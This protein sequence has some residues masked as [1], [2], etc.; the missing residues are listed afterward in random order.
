MIDT[1]ELNRLDAQQ[2]REVVQSLIGKVSAQQ[3]EISRRDAVVQGL[4]TQRI[5]ACAHR[6]SHRTGPVQPGGRESGGA[7]QMV[8]VV[9]KNP[10]KYGF[11][12]II[13]S[14]K[15]AVLTDDP[16]GLYYRLT[17]AVAQ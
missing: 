8:E 3:G 17:D 6:G 2:L 7:E 15:L 4:F 10:V 14:G 9:A 11:D 1:T 5:S 12:P 13:L 16:M